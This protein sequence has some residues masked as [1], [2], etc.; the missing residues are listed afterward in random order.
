VSNQ[1]LL[2]AAR[3][4]LAGIHGQASEGSRRQTGRIRRALKASLH[5]RAPGMPEPSKNG[6]QNSLHMHIG[7]RTDTYTRESAGER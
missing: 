3:D 1:R 7:W 4:Q 5:H 2:S 6:R